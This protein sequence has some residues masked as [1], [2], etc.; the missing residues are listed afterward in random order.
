MTK[1]KSRTNR[2]K[3]MFA[4]YAEM[5]NDMFLPTP[6]RMSEVPLMLSP[7]KRNECVNDYMD[8][9]KAIDYLDGRQFIKVRKFQ[10]GT[11]SKK[12][13]NKKSTKKG[14]NKT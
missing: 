11:N 9:L 10:N 14:A 8:L 3:D 4:G 1:V 12:K 6:I 7:N 13:T 5:L 2:A